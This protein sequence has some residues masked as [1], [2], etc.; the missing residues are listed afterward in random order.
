MLLLFVDCYDIMTNVNGNSKY[1]LRNVIE[2]V[3]IYSITND[4]VTIYRIIWKVQ[5]C[6]WNVVILTKRV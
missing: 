5:E 3:S 4:F 2:N 6:E 1:V